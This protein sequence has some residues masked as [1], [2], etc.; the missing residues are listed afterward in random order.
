MVRREHL[1]QAVV[2]GEPLFAPVHIADERRDGGRMA[3]APGRKGWGMAA[4]AILAQQS[5]TKCAVFHLEKRQ[6]HFGQ[7]NSCFLPE[8]A[9]LSVHSSTPWRS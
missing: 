8:S 3:P 9:P 2:K 5:P 1:R 4:P 6:Q 7:A